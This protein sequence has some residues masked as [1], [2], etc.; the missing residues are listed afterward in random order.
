MPLRPFAYLRLTSS[1]ASVLAH[2]FILLNGPAPS[3]TTLAV[4]VSVPLV[5][6]CDIGDSFEEPTD[7]VEA[8]AVGSFV[9]VA[10]RRGLGVCGR[11]VTGLVDVDRDNEFKVAC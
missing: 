10:V 1:K 11:N 5:T 9:D 7:R 3:S 8:L 4:R 2:S 6:Q